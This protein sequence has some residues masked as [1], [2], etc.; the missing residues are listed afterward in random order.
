MTWLAPQTLRCRAEWMLTNNHEQHAV[1][2]SV[3]VLPLKPLEEASHFQGDRKEWDSHLSQAPHQGGALGS[4]SSQGCHLWIPKC[5][6]PPPSPF[7]FPFLIHPA[8]SLLHS[9]CIILESLDVS[10]SLCLAPWSLAFLLDFC[11][12][13]KPPLQAQLRL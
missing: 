7:L 8:F 1:C 6:W 10:S 9:P 2:V 4:L 11:P 13:V 3:K 5:L 12:L